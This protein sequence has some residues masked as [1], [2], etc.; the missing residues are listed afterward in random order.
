MIEKHPFIDKLKNIGLVKAGE[1]EW[2]FRTLS[3]S[4]NV[5]TVRPMNNAKSGTLKGLDRYLSIKIDEI[6]KPK[7]MQV[8]IIRNSIPD[9]KVGNST[10]IEPRVKPIIPAN[11]IL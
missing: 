11:V 8:R 5:L 7:I 1:Q 6:T 3:Q 10:K 2:D 4:G 9:E